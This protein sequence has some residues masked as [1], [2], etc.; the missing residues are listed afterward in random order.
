M[1]FIRHSDEKIELRGI[2]SLVFTAV[3]KTNSVKIKYHS[4]KIGGKLL[5]SSSQNFVIVQ[6]VYGY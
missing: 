3:I 6:E 2:L 5:S 1:Q 4:T